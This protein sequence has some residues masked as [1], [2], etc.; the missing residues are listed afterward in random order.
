MKNRPPPCDNSCR[1]SGVVTGSL[2][3]SAGDRTLD[4]GPKKMTRKKKP[5]AIYYRISTAQQAEANGIDSQVLVV[6]QWLAAYGVTKTRVFKDLAKSGTNL[7]RPAFQRMLAAIRRGEHDLVVAH[8]LSRIGRSQIDLLE[9]MREMDK[10]GVRCVF[11]RDSIDCTSA[12]GKL[13]LGVLSSVVQFERERLSERTK[14]GVAAARQDDQ[15]WGMGKVPAHLRPEP[16]NKLA[17]NEKVARLLDRIEPMTPEK[18]GEY[19]RK[20]AAE[21]G[22]TESGL[23]SRVQRARG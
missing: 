1:V 21:W 16:A 2:K 10:R 7:K 5:A 9:F 13:L 17:S 22:M 20:K 19:I 15:S 12:T 14:A 4:K 11:V 3:G 18:R 23:R 6:E 8:D